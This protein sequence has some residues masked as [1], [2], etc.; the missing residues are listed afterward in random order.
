MNVEKS[1]K[2]FAERL[3]KEFDSSSKWLNLCEEAISEIKIQIKDNSDTKENEDRLNTA[4]AALAFY[5]YALC[6]Y[7]E[8]CASSISTFSNEDLTEKKIAISVAKTAW[9]NARLNIIDILK[10]A[11]FVFRGIK[12]YL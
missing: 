2:K 11:G 3:G 1:F 9:E 10:D 4:A 7:K 5:K 8:M 6:N 12:Q